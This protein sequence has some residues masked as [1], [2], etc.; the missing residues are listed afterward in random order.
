MT[1]PRTFFVVGVPGSNMLGVAVYFNARADAFALVNP[2]RRPVAQLAEGCE[3]VRRYWDNLRCPDCP[4]APPGI[5]QA[6]DVFPRFV[7]PVTQAYFAL[8]GYAEEWHG[9]PL[10]YRLLVRHIPLVDFWL[11]VTCDPLE[12]AHRDWPACRIGE[13]QDELTALARVTGGIVIDGNGELECLT[14]II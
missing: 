1:N 12:S 2:H 7:L 6:L 4:D 5:T 11:C 13:C 9:E 14:P 3:K 10:D 8:G